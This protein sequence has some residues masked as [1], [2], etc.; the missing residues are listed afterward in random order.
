[1]LVKRCPLYPS[2]LWNMIQ[3]KLSII[4]ENVPENYQFTILDRALILAALRRVMVIDWQA[5]GV[6][7]AMED[8]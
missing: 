3:D 5:N 7:A 6:L 1:M 2:R 4:I 8:R